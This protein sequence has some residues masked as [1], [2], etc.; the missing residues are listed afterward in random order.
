MKTRLL[1]AVSSFV[2]ASVLI[3]SA[4]SAAPEVEGKFN[5]GSD[6]QVVREDLAARLVRLGLSQE[7][8]T[9][10]VGQLTADDL[11]VL[12]DHP[13]QLAV[14]GVKD[15]TLIIIAGIII[16]PSLLIILLV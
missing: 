2:L 15:T 12:A 4:V 6:Q 11:A 3:P 9:T 5:V 1:L 8:A 16:L 10:R 7:E 13:E 14:G